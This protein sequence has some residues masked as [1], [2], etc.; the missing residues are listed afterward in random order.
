MYNDVFLV[1]QYCL[2]KK[3]HCTW[4]RKRSVCYTNETDNRVCSL[5]EIFLGDVSKVSSCIALKH[6]MRTSKMNLLVILGH[7][8]SLYCKN[9]TKHVNT[10]SAQII[11][12]L[13]V[14]TDDPYSNDCSWSIENKIISS[15][16]NFNKN[17]EFSARVGYVYALVC[18]PKFTVIVFL[19][20]CS[21]LVIV[22]GTAR[23]LCDVGTQFSCT[24]QSHFALKRPMHDSGG[25][26]L[27][28]QPRGLWRTKWH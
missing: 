17:S 12:V 8:M 6:G 26:P 28:F 5:L 21:W 27:D 22:L 1:L 20:I 3:N 16:M 2:N 10:L 7:K 19:K 13:S 4:K 11:E 15:C 23:Y 25:W 24:I 14:K 18:F 9:P